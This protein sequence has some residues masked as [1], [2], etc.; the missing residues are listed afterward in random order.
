M[1]Q[2]KVTLAKKKRCETWFV[3][4]VIHPD[5]LTAEDARYLAKQL[6]EKADE[7]ERR[8]QGEQN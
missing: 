3:G 1:P 7:A 4:I 6:N 5:L 2:G 8:N